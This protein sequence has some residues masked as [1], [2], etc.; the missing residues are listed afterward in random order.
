MNPYPRQ[1]IQNHILQQLRREFHQQ[2]LAQCRR[3]AKV[4]RRD[5]HSNQRCQ[6]H[7]PVQRLRCVEINARIFFLYSFRRTCS[8][9]E[10]KQCVLLWRWVSFFRSHFGKI[11]RNVSEQSPRSKS[12]HNIAFTSLTSLTC[13]TNHIACDSPIMS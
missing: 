11:K 2:A 8:T 5:P 12:N 6:Y 4:H 1:Q 7:Q 10:R 3:E 13:T 9:P